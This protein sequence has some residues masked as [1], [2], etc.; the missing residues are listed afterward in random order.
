MHGNQEEV[1]E[2]CLIEHYEKYYRIAL[3][4]VG[5]KEDAQDIVQ[6]S[7]YKAIFYS[8]KLREKKYADTWI[9]RIVINEAKKCLRKN[10]KWDR[11]IAK[12]KSEET[13]SQF[14][15]PETGYQRIILE[16]A[17]KILSPKERSV[18][19]LRYCEGMSL[20]QVADVIG[21]KLSTVKSRLY[22]AL[23]KM[24]MNMS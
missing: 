3:G 1:I 18:V 23:E 22:R 17:M 10:Q 15:D 4:Y 5:N 24:R 9:C 6:E 2:Q 11:E 14:S 20:E 16:E 12:W 13:A 21:E 19:V 7:A 8:G